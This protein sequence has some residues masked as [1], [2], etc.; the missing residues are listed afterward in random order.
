M[1]KYGFKIGIE[2][3]IE[4]SFAVS[5]KNT[6]YLKIS[7][8]LDLYSLNGKGISTGSHMEVFISNI[9]PQTR[10]QNEIFRLS[11]FTCNYL[12]VRTSSPR[13]SAPYEKHRCQPIPANQKAIS[14]AF[15]NGLV[16]FQSGKV[17]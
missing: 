3:Q 16:W 6:Y 9:W 4:L 15:M 14:C 13:Q 8:T 12:P 5:I 7:A 2:R 1:L 10:I 11:C 17:Y